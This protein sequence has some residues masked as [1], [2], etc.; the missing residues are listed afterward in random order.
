MDMKDLQQIAQL[1]DEKLKPVKDELK[2]HGIML[3][4]HGEMLK[5]HG[6]VLESHGKILRSL[7][8]DQETMLAMLDKE[9]MSQRKRLTKLEE[10]VGLP[11]IS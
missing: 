11:S 6:K 1:L 5:K 9:Q 8:K 2:E 4:E 10:H 3:K 7:K